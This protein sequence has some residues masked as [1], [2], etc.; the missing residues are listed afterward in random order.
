MITN[1]SIWLLQASV[2][3]VLLAA[4][5][6]L[7]LEKL[8]FFQGN[9]VFLLGGLISCLTLPLFLAPFPSMG[10][11]SA[12][13]F[14]E[15]YLLNSP[16]KL[17]SPIS[18]TLSKDASS[19]SLDWSLLLARFLMMSYFLGVGYRTFK[20]LGS[21][22]QL[23]KLR[24]N[25]VILDSTDRIITFSQAK[26]PTFSF[27][28]NI[29]LN[30]NT[31]ELSELEM[32]QVIIHEREHI[33]Q[34]HSFDLMF[35][36]IMGIVFWFNP[37]V[38]Y[39]S[40]ALR[41]VHE[42]MVDRE[43]GIRSS[44]SAGYGKLLVKLAAQSSKVALTHTFSESQI[45]HRITMLIKP[46]S[47]PMQKLRF[48]FV[49]PLMGSIVV[50]SS[51]ISQLETPLRSDDSEMV[52]TEP[53]KKGNMKIAKITWKGN[54]TYSS[55]ELNKVLGIKMGDN[56]DSLQLEDRLLGSNNTVAALYM[57][58]GY[59]FF[60]TD[61][62]T[63]LNEN[64]ISLNILLNEGQKA[65]IGKIIVKGNKKISA[66]TILNLIDIKPNEYFNRSKLISSQKNLAEAGKFDPAQIIINPY[67]D[68]NSFSNNKEGV[69]DLEF[70]LTER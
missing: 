10:H 50:L 11:W 46:K 39:L 13:P 18:D 29:F 25:A 6:K 64:Q 22:Y 7:L 44:L 57:D 48:L 16:L 53:D 52:Q 56:Y 21:L 42:Y 58:Q 65:R 62:T 61:L 69:V 35:C 17:S 67:P 8:T 54:T 15:T 33:I 9:R 1:F 26:F 23:T 38:R 40:N 70:V 45:F 47:S 34:K 37:C 24:K 36:E 63:T 19:Y 41:S 55:K 14:T 66:Q 32:Q 2:A 3:I 51:Y 28:N 12:L 30:E 31:T 60:H 49:L 68:H 5:Y 4:C 59:L 27:F 20:F 43:I